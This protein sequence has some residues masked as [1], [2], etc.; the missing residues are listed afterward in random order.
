MPDSPGEVWRGFS[1]GTRARSSISHCQSVTK[2]TR[3]FEFKCASQHLRFGRTSCG[4]RKMDGIA[5]RLD[6]PHEPR[7]RN[8][9]EA[10][11]RRTCRLPDFLSSTL[12]PRPHYLG[13][14]RRDCR[15]LRPTV[16]T[17]ALPTPRPLFEPTDLLGPLPLPTPPHL[18]DADSKDGDDVHME[19]GH[20]RPGEL[21]M[22]SPP[23]DFE[24]EPSDLED[25]VKALM[26]SEQR[27][28]PSFTSS[29]ILDFDEPP[30]SLPQPPALTPGTS[31]I[32]Y[33]GAKL[34]SSAA[35]R[36][37]LTPPLDIDTARLDHLLNEPEPCF[38]PPLRAET[39]SGSNISF[40]RRTKPKPP[41]SPLCIPT[42]D[43][44]TNQ[45]TGRSK[46]F[47]SCRRN[48]G[49]PCNTPTSTVGGSG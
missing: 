19:E 1:A 27:D 17:S 23:P 30:I 38:L 15:F 20:V 39:A 48:I 32:E 28:K 21:R 3:H 8:R 42:W 6:N 34:M 25:E 43:V 37:T 2:L 41:V 47:G 45:M 18:T 29:R 31:L 40:K 10:K 35:S 36:I 4:E 16:M 46:R 44:R 33:H 5:P 24:Y 9:S 14:E 12:L 26:K 49:S 13:T 22:E 11:V 7:G